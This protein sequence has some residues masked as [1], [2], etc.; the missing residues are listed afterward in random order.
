MWE[1]FQKTSLHNKQE[2]GLLKYRGVSN[3]ESLDT[4]VRCF[5]SEI[6]PDSSIHSGIETFNPASVLEKH[7]FGC[8][9][10]FS[11]VSRK[12]CPQ[13]SSEEEKPNNTKQQTKHVAFAVSHVSNP[14]RDSRGSLYLAH[15]GKTQTIYTLTWRTGSVSWGISAAHERQS[16]FI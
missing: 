2:L 10:S 14:S 3:R 1:P 12:K 4:Q 16:Y 13:S 8:S 15:K 5:W 11:L 9:S 6:F 7:S